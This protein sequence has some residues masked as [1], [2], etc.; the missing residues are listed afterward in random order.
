MCKL[1]LK[2]SKTS[3]ISQLKEN[4]LLLVKLKHQMKI[5]ESPNNTQAILVNGI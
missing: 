4:F 3:K 5:F 2:C 1:E